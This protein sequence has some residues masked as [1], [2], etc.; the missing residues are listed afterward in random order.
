[1]GDNIIPVLYKQAAIYGYEEGIQRTLSVKAKDFSRQW[2]EHVENYYRAYLN[3]PV[4]PF[5]A[6][7][8]LFEDKKAIDEQDFAPSISPNGKYIVFLSARN[9]FTLDLYLADARSRKIISRLKTEKEDA[10]GNALRL[11]ESAAAWSPDSKYLAFIT[12]EQGKHY[13]NIVEAS[14]GKT[15]EKILVDD[16]QSLLNPAWSPDGK[17]IVFSGVTQGSSDLYVYDMKSKKTEQLTSDKFSDLQASW[18]PDGK[19]LVFITDRF[20]GTDFSSYYFG[21]YEIASLNLEDRSIN[22]IPLFSGV[23][24]I[25]PAFGKDNRLYFIAAPDG[26]SNI[27][28]YDFTSTTVERVTHEKTAT[29][30]ITELSPALSIATKTGDLVYSVFKETGYQLFTLKYDK[31]KAVPIDPAGLSNNDAGQLPPLNRP[32]DQEVNGYIESVPG[33]VVDDSLFTKS[34]Y[35]AKLSLSGIS[36]AGIGAGAGPYGAGFGGAV[37]ILFSD[38]LE[39]HIVYGSIQASGS[40]QDIGGLVGYV[41]QKKRY[42]WGLS[43]SHIPYGYANY[44]EHY[45]TINLEGVTTDIYVLDQ[46]I[47]RQFD[48]KLSLYGA[49]PF[50]RVNRIEG[51]L[52]LDVINY[53]YIVQRYNYLLNGVQFSQEKF[54]LDAP[55]GFQFGTASIA[56][57]GDDSRFGFT[58]PLSGYRYRLEA[59][60]TSGAFSIRDSI[61]GFPGL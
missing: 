45:D 21:N 20:S 6:G 29:A 32:K 7:R 9:I 58:S 41:N 46:Y 40:I 42:S 14:K 2:Q 1:M 4:D 43:F 38:M 34:P 25:D 26:V 59:G 47:L 55:K 23:N 19:S 28:R 5:S 11:I 44:L 8:R 37:N 30:G 31:I 35:K 27:Y 60:A 13:V 39:Q 16:V 52:S 3:E 12:Y 18:S 57:V 17:K 53:S 36:N 50:T 15:K 48:D 24:H 10:H 22:H 54:K 33:V 56:L 51:S 49:Y 61:G